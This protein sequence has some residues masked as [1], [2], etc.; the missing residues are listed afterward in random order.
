MTAYHSLVR[1]AGLRKGE[2]ILIHAAAG[3][4]G[5]A[6]IVVAQHMGAN[7]FVTCSTETKR[8]LFIEHYNIN[9]TNILSSRDTSFASVIM[10]ATG[11][12]GVDV[13]LNSLSGSLLKATWSCIA[14]FGRFVEIGKV[15]MEAARSLDMTPFTRCATYVGVDTLQLNEYN[16]PLAHEALA[17]SVHICHARARAEGRSPVFPIQKYSTSNMKKA[18]RQIQGGS[19]L[20]KVVL[21]PGD[22]DRVNVSSSLTD[23]FPHFKQIS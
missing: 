22:E 14:R 20:G 10:T 1:V 2:T 23:F 13:A 4:V 8:D 6:A 7:M 12:K 16:G 9:P 18:M 11:G 17:E 21:I 5:Q 3:G 15:D 19:H